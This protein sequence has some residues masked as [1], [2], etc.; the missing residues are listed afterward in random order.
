MV[1]QFLFLLFS[2]WSIF[3]A[4]LVVLLPN[5]VYSLI[6]LLSTLIAI[7]GIFFVAGAELVGAIQLMVYAVA[8]PIF[9]VIVLTALPWEKAYKRESH[10]RS[11]G[12]LT[13]PLLI[14][15]YLQ[16]LFVL[17]SGILIS[18]KG[19]IRGLIKKFG[20]SQVIGAILFNRYFLPFEVISL[21]LLLG[22]I[23]AILI[24]RKEEKTYGQD[25]R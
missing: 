1:R 15:L 21:A 20:N 3:S 23:G 4:L 6:S 16:I 19:Q 9:Y 14:I 8:I 22:M 12:I 10:Y 2:L 5:P 11:E 7:S 13:F 25:S 18:P 17:V 24:G